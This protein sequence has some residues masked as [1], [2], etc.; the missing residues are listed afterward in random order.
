MARDFV[1][2][3]TIDKY[4]LDDEASV[5]AN[6]IA[7]YGEK[8]AKIKTEVDYAKRRVAKVYGE[9]D[10]KYRRNPPADLK[11]TEKVMESLVVTDKRVEE[12]EQ[13]YIEA[14]AELNILE[15]AMEAFR[16]KSKDIGNLTTLWSGGY[17][18]VKQAEKL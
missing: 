14:K 17:F 9:V 8:L 15:V 16:D 2:D 6:H 4:R 1:K 5:N 13:A 11:V 3:S 10:L 18:S 12:A 7:F